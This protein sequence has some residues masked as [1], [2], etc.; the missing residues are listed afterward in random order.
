MITLPASSIRCNLHSAVQEEEGHRLDISNILS[1]R[2]QLVPTIMTPVA[3]F[4]LLVA[5]GMGFLQFYNVWIVTS[6]G[7][8]DDSTFDHVSFIS[9]T[10]G[11]SINEYPRPSSTFILNSTTMKTTGHDSFP[12]RGSNS[13]DGLLLQE[14]SEKFG[15]HTIQPGNNEKGAMRPSCFDDGTSCACDEI[16]KYLEAASKFTVIHK[17]SDAIPQYR[18]IPASMGSNVTYIQYRR[19]EGPKDGSLTAL[20]EYN[21]TVLPLTASDLDPKLVNYLTGRY[22]PDISDDEADRVKYLSIARGSNLH[23]C[24]GGLRKFGQPTKEQSYLSLSLLDEHLQPIPNASCAVNTFQAL[25]PDCYKSQEMSPFQD[26][27][28][29]AARSTIGYDKKDQLFMV[30]SDSFTVILP[31]DIR[32]VPGPTNDASDW[33]TKITSVPVPMIQETDAASDLF[34]GNGL[35]VRFMTNIKPENVKRCIR[36]LKHNAMDWKKNYHVF[37]ITDANGTVSTYMEIHPHRIRSTRKINFYANKFEK[38]GDWE[39][40]PNRTFEN[41]VKDGKRDTRDIQVNL[42]KRGEPLQ[43]FESPAKQGRAQGRGTACCIDIDFNENITVKVGISHFVTPNRNYLSRFYAFALTPPK[44]Q[45]VALSGA[46]CFEKMNKALDMNADTQIFTFPDQHMP[47]NI[48]NIVYDC[49]QITFASGIAEYHADKNYAVIS[50]G[51]N[52]C[53]S[54]SMV[55]SKNRIKELLNVNASDSWKQW[56]D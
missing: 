12:I 53:Y 16:G 9:A 24:A 52:D 55:V 19:M 15:S 34:Y 21:P 40:V 42:S 47:L 51:V 33:K 37:D 6:Q 22:H 14:Y 11:R 48:S 25:L 44:F 36:I 29:I 18:R 30:A 23:N 1:V 49:P 8:I 45:L 17:P 13:L 2:K 3:N 26:Y 27:Q 7:N 38:Y 39:L 32:R 31:L 35:Q 43:Q 4:M 28:I 56:I 5:L 46:F 10:N 54:R 50:Y 20:V 41:V